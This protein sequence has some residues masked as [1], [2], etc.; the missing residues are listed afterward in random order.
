MTL[1]F[2]LLGIYFFIFLGYIS[3]KIF[4]DKIDEKTFVL[5]SI[6]FLQP[7]LV[8]WGLTTKEIDASVINA[9]LIF[10]LVVSCTLVVSFFLS[11]L[12]FK[13][14]KDRSIATVA[15]IVGNTG[16]L[17]I[18]LGIAL[19]GQSSVIYTSIIN[20]A[21]VFLVYTV[22]VYFYGRGSFSVKESLKNIFKL[23][24]MWFG[25]L[26]IAF[27]Y[28]DFKVSDEILLP[29]EMGAYATMVMQLAIFGMYLYSVKYKEIDWKLFNFVTFMKFVFIPIISVFILKMF[30]LDDLV[31]NVIL[32]EL[33]VPLA[34]MNVNL[35]SLYDC[36]PTQVAFLIF[37]TSVGFL[38]YLFGIV[39]FLFR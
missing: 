33:L 37:A 31:Y 8:F 1:I 22:G 28:A 20:L 4:E 14:Q 23:P 5:F 34:V 24:V 25:F 15:S 27:N 26:A 17:G 39:G 7:I 12:F 19:F 32:L 21:N 11:Q 6:Y 18:P 3:K 38:F 29:L 13:E 36:K 35:A 30:E 16:N 9:P 2:S 10:A